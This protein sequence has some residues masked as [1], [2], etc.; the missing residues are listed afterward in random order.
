MFRT[1]VNR[2]PGRAVSHRELSY[3]NLN[4]IRI[5]YFQGHFSDVGR[6]VANG[7]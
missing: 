1:N 3:L 2:V 4:L 7:S 6:L 5:F